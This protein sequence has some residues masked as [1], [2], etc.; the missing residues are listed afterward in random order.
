MRRDLVVLGASAGGLEALRVIVA[1][2]PADFPA[3]ICVVVHTAPDSPGVIGGILRRAGNLEAVMVRSRQRLDPGTIYVACPDH[4]I[5]V[6]PSKVLATRGPRENRFR[7][8]VDPLFRSAAQAYGPRVI[9][10]ILSGGLD[11]GT[12]GLWAVKRMGGIA[13]VQEPADALVASMPASA[14][15]HVQV[16]HRLPVAQIAAL[17]DRLTREDIAEAGGYVMPESTR[18]EVDIAAA[19]SPL[20]AGVRTLGEPSTYACPECHGV[21]LSLREAE[22][23]RFRCHTGHA[24]TAESL[25]AEMDDAIEHSLIVS[26]RALQEKTIFVRDMAQRAEGDATLAKELRKRAEDTQAMAEMLR[27]ATLGLVRRA[28]AAE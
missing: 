9:G 10:V 22:R 28:E 12:A 19:N 20:D 14:L 15:Q 7:P 4:H 17:L 6:E 18:I 27:E 8:A 24:Y 26:M 13:V 25:I 2:L 3:A 11:D 5:V 23:V 16:D 21:L 1:S